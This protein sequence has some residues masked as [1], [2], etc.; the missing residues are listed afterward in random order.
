MGNAF[1]TGDF[2]TFIHYMHPKIVEMAGGVDGLKNILSQASRQM[3]IAGMSIDA[4]T[5]DSMT[6]IL[7]AGASLQTTVQ[8][9]SA[10]KVPDGRTI[11]T[12]TLICLS[13]DNGL[14]WKFVD[15]HNK[16][17]VDMRKA[18]PNI[19]PALTIPPAYPPVHFDH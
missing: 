9:H 4:I 3:S 5:I 13:A 11:A 1:A 10:F 8:Q 7:K 6:N 12:T 2:K 14:H 18:L 17:I 15:T 19:S 16:T